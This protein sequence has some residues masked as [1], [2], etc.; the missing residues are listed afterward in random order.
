MCKVRIGKSTVA[1]GF[2]LAAVS[3]LPGGLGRVP[4]QIRG[5]CG[6]LGPNARSVLYCGVRA[7]RQKKAAELQ[8]V[9]T[10][11]NYGLSEWSY[12]LS[13]LVLVI[14]QGNDVLCCTQ[15]HLLFDLGIPLSGRQPRTHLL[16]Q[17]CS[18]HNYPR[19]VQTGSGVN[20]AADK[21]ICDTATEWALEIFIIKTIL[22]GKVLI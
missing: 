2:L 16:A 6:N 21:C 7:V 12:G 4:S 9:F 3:D 15:K 14:L 20:M 5:D 17:K 22:N 19:K 10:K 8:M 13:L 11:A 1:S 18:L